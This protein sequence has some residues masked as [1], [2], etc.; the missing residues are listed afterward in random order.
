LFFS[1]LQLLWE[2]PAFREFLRGHHE[3]LAVNLRRMLQSSS[4]LAK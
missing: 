3:H 2:L 4:E 1:L